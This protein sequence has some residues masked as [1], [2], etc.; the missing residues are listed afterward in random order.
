MRNPRHPIAPLLVAL[1]LVA[2]TAFASPPT[3][4]VA[5][6]LAA[7]ADTLVDGYPGA[8][9]ARVEGDAHLDLRHGSVDW[10]DADSVTVIPGVVLALGAPHDDADA[11]LRFATSPAAQRL[12]IEAGALPPSVTVTDQAGRTFEVAQPVERLASPYSLATYLA[13]GVGAGDRVVMAGFLGAR[14]PAGAAAMERIDARFPELSSVPSQETT[15]VEFIATIAP[16][17]VF[18]AARSEWIGPVEALGIPVIVF[19]GESTEGLRSA[20]RLTGLLLGPDAA[21]RAEAWIAYYDH[22]LERVAA[23]TAGAAAEPQSVLFTG[24]KRT[25]VASGAMYQSAL[26]AAAGGRSTTAALPGHWNEVGL[27]Q[28]LVW[29]PDLILVPPYGGASVEAIVD[30]VDWQLLDAVRAGHV[31]RVP[32]LVAPWD[33]PVPDSVLAVVWLAEVLHPGTIDLSCAEEAA[34]FYR[35]FYRYAISESEVAD[36]CER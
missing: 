23:A 28:V 16:D 4:S 1:L 15:N 33:T 17:V 19:D 30:D 5:A 9:P 27:E 36:L 21:A 26:I 29:N 34:F 14:D 25:T 24:T 20:M 32:K 7:V 31:L 12:L 13:Y 18:G 35:R 2:A 10:R 6:D 8:A 11:F 3:L 22:V